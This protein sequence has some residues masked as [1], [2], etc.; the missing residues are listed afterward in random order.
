MIPEELIAALKTKY[1]IHPL[2]FHRSKEKAKTAGELFDMLDTMPK[3]FPIIWDE[4]NKK[5]ITTKDLFQA[6]AFPTKDQ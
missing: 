5:W 3:I 6:K 1:V 4:E 2:L